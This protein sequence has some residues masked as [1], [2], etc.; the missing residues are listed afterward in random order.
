[1][2]WLACDRSNCSKERDKCRR[3][4]DKHGYNEMGN[5]SGIPLRSRL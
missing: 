2:K 3:R 5:T 1:M 4:L